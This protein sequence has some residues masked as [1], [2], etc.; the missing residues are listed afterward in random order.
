MNPKVVVR[1]ILISLLLAAPAPLLLTGIV[2]L[3][4]APLVA[5][6]MAEFA[7]SGIAGTY[8]AVAFASFIVLCAG[9]LAAAGLAPPVIITPPLARARPAPRQPAASTP[10]QNEED[11]WEEEEDFI[12]PNDGREEGEVKWFNTNKGYGF[13]TRDSGEDVF[14]HFRAIRGRGPRMLTEG[15]IVRYHVIQN[16]R[17]LQADDV[18]IIDE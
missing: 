15:Q 18:S 13:I 8:F 17:G 3:F 11:D 9:T 4:N 7:I 14:V 10:T 1:C 5:A 12:D 2:H 16:E 6:L